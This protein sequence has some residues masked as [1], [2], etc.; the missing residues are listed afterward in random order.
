MSEK[1]RSC[2]DPVAYLRTGSYS[3][4]I[5]FGG[6]TLA[7]LRGAPFPNDSPFLVT[8]LGAS[9]YLH[10]VKG[11]FEVRNNMAPAKKIEIKK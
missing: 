1:T 10:L 11:K 3:C 4:R 9:Y 7:P 8:A 2:E 6:N 5:R